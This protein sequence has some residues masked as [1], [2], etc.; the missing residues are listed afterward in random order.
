MS[1]VGH[2]EKKWGPLG[3]GSL[4]VMTVMQDGP[5]RVW[6]SVVDVRWRTL[7]KSERPLG[8]G[9]LTVM[10]VCTG[11]TVVGMTV[12]RMCLF[13]DTWTKLDSGVLGMLERTQWR[14]VVGKMVRHWGLVL[15]FSDRTGDSLFIPYDP[16]EILSV[17]TYI[18]LTQITSKLTM[19]KH[20]F[21]MF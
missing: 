2:L 10:T 5:S 18:C 12:C 8:I 15:S 9:S 7:R 21:L 11:R 13:V 17:L 1:V 16:N 3:Q 20:L 14:S 19:L 6:R 4:T